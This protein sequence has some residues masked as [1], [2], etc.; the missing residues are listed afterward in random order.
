MVEGLPGTQPEPAHDKD[1]GRALKA[2]A[3]LGVVFPARYV[4]DLLKKN[5]DVVWSRAV[6]RTKSMAALAADG[7][8]R[9]QEFSAAP[10]SFNP[11]AACVHPDFETAWEAMHSIGS[12]R[13]LPGQ[14]ETR[15]ES[16]VGQAARQ[17]RGL[18][19]VD[20]PVPHRSEKK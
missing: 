18:Q 13:D 19:A 15:T 2:N 17:I 14:C 6:I 9:R 1:T 12:S 3:G 20:L 4:V 7:P 8:G 5:K 10:T 11:S 16:E